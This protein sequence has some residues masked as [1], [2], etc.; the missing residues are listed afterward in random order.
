M[1]ATKLLGF[2]FQGGRD[3]SGCRG[4]CYSPAMPDSLKLHGVELAAEFA[5]VVWGGAQP[6][7]HRTLSGNVIDA[8]WA[9]RCG[10]KVIARY[11]ALAA[12]HALPALLC[13]TIEQ[14]QEQT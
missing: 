5:R 1:T 13:A 3:A 10:R 9:Y 11:D 8:P 7:F 14:P 6:V 2:K 12:R 4:R